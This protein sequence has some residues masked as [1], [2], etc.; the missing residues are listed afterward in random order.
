MVFFH[1]L[2]TSDQALSTDI[3]HLCRKI[4]FRHEIW[5]PKIQITL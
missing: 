2:D 3:S 1:I 4:R 5:H